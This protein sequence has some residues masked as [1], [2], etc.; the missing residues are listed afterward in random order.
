M[1]KVWYSRARRN[2]YNKY[3]KSKFSR[4]NTYKYRSSKA[5]ASQI[6]ALNKKINRIQ[7]LTRPEIK[8]KNAGLSDITL[9]TGLTAGY[10]YDI[11]PLVQGTDFEGN[12]VRLNSIK[13][14]G[15][16]NEYAISTTGIPIQA[17]L[18][19]IQTKTTRSDDPA[20]ADIFRSESSGR[21]TSCP[22]PML[23]R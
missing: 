14:Y 7:R 18:V 2:K 12:L 23:S 11:S 3:R 5:Q 21:T 15:S 13:Y 10:V 22:A 16:F 8:I 20:V 9:S 6:Y 17:R 1:V 19:I 4:F